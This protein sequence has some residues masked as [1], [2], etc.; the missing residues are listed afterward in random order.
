MCI[1]DSRHTVDERRYGRNFCCRKIEF[2]HAFIQPAVLNYICDQLA[3]F[4]VQDKFT[5]DQI[6][7]L[8]ATSGV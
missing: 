6:G 4:I 5:A 7:A 3:V 2:W 1:R 8:F